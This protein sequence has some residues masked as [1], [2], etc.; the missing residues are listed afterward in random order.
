MDSG[1]LNFP[2]NQSPKKSSAHGQNPLSTDKKMT[3]KLALEHLKAI[4]ALA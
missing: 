1:D 3:H 2:K 4:S